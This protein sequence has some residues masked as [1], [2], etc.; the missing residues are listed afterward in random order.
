MTKAPADT[1]DGKIISMTSDKLTTTCGAGKQHCH[2]MAKDAEV[3]C[4]GKAGQTSDL[5]AGMH[6]KVTTGMDDKSVATHVECCKRTPA[7]TVEA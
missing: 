6:V 3:T 2:T 1:H 7:A 5:K 4:D